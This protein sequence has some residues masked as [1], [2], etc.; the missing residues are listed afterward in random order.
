ML[1]LEFPNYTHQKIYENM[2]QEW[3]DFEETPTS[4]GRL[5]IWNDYTEFLSEI[6]K[7]VTD[8][9]RGVNAT[10]YFLFEGEK[11]LWAIQVRH[12]IE[13]PNLKETWWHIWYGIRPS[14]R[15]KWYATMMLKMWLI[16]AQKLWIKK[17]L[18]S[19]EPDNI[20]SE[21]VILK[22]GGIYNATVKKDSGIYKT[23]W[24]T[25]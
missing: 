8:N 4:P 6:Q 3:R 2:I 13:H 25:I 7:D 17:V 21:K 22:N 15:K 10:L 14:E 16:E 11:I 1:R 20:G 9:Q 12:H 19:C 18:I 5:F 24:I 23:F